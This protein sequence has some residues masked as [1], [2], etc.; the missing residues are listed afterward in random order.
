MVTGYSII[1]GAT[2]WTSNCIQSPNG[3]ETNAECDVGQ[4][5]EP[6]LLDNYNQLGN[7][8]VDPSDSNYNG[9]TV[10]FNIFEQAHQWVKDNTLGQ[11]L[12]ALEVTALWI[13]FAILV[14]HRI[15]SSFG[16]KSKES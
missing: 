7:F 15:S 11:T 9:K 6:S 10:G 2:Q 12:Y 3:Q 16:D 14:W 8:P 5:G 13:G 1:G 4:S